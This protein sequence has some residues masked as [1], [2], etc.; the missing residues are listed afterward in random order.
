MLSDIIQNPQYT[1]YRIPKKRGGWRAIC[2]PQGDLKEVQKRINKWLKAYYQRI[3]PDCVF[4]FTCKP[5]N[6]VRYCNIVKN[7]EPHVGKRFVL[8]IDL[9]NFF[10]NISARVI[11]KLFRSKQ[12]NLDKGTAIG[13]TLL[14]TYQGKLPTGAPTSPVISNFVCIPLDTALSDFSDQNKLTYTRY[15]DDL[16]FST[17]HPF[18]Q[19]NIS[20]ICQLIR[21]HGFHINHRKFRIQS[22]FGRQ[23]VTGIVVNRRVNV[24]RTRLKKIRAMIH[25]LKTN[26]LARAAAKHFNVQ[27]NDERDV[28]FLFL[29]RLEGYINFVGQVR[30]KEDM[31]YVKLK[32]DYIL[33]KD[34]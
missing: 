22:S 28:N 21:Q 23:T 34:K 9:E 14:L 18:T 29:K 26:G 7:A 31:Y 19:D 24:N 17:D 1:T 27:E 15:A 32:E 20:A 3:K 33:N 30:G 11:L 10:P 2:A 6:E 5:K 12:F 8:N 25:D 16:T 13:L 4:G